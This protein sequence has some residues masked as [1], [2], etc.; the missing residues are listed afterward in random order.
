MI[1]AAD[2]DRPA[3]Q[4]PR[5]DDEHE[6]EDRNTER[7]DGDRAAYHA[8]RAD[9]VEL[10]PD[11]REEETEEERAAVAEED[12]RRREVVS[13]EPEASAGHRDCQRRDEEI[14]LD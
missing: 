1:G 5:G 7:E 4:E 10:Q 3:R 6:V 14:A 8:T 9:Q 11:R 12:P 13:E 2:V